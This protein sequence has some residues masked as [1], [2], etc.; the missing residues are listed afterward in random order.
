MGE[1]YAAIV[2]QLHKELETRGLAYGRERPHKFGPCPV[3]RI[4][5]CITHHPAH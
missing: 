5:V 4:H 1:F 3:C 2:E